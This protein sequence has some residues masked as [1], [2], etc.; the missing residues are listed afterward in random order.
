MVVFWGA[1]FQNDAN[2]RHLAGIGIPVTPYG[3]LS[4]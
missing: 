3:T 2:V 4:F 1:K